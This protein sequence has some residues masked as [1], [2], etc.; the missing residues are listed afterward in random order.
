MSRYH[1]AR[2]LRLLL[3]LSLLLPALLFPALPVRSAG[4]ILYVDVAAAGATH[5][6]TT[7]ETAYLDLQAALAGAGAASAGDRVWVAEGRYTPGPAG[8]PGSTF[9]IPEGVAVYGGFAGGETSLAARDPVAHPTV[10]SGDLAGDDTVDARGVTLTAG[11]ISGTNAYHVVTLNG[12]SGATM[13][14][15]LTIT[16]GDARNATTRA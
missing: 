6:G 5:D 15:G 3:T 8:S 1:A 9:S 7:W 12:V 14:E 11:G 16:A 10:L 4:R 13:L 2:A